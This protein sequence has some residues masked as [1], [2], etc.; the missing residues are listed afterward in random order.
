MY[1]AFDVAGRP[2]TNPN[3]Q[4]YIAYKWIKINITYG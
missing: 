4:L 1:S 3:T 2:T